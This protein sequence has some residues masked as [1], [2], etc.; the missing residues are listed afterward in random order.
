MKDGPV[1]GCRPRLLGNGWR[2]SAWNAATSAVSR[3]IAVADGAY[4]RLL[5]NDDARL[6]RVFD[7]VGGERRDAEPRWPTEVTSRSDTSLVKAS[8]NGLTPMP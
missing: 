2:E 7:V 3:H 5:L 1:F 4:Q 6:H 8:R